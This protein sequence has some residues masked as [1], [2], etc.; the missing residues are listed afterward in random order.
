MQQGLSEHWRKLTVQGVADAIRI[1]IENWP[2]NCNWIALAAL[3]GRLGPGRVIY[4]TAEFA[5]E[6]DYH[7]WLEL[8]DSNIVD[9]TRWHYEGVGP[10]LYIG[11]SAGYSAFPPPEE[12]A[13]HA[14][15]RR[16]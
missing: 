2:G 8:D 10:Y 13:W 1:P 9:F 5:S 6:V 3:R 15:L 11:D 4:G 16:V 12:P 14:R 7:A